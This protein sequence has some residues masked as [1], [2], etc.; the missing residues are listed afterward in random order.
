MG[1]LPRKSLTRERGEPDRGEL[2]RTRT[3]SCDPKQ[4]PVVSQALTYTDRKQKI[5]LRGCRALVRKRPKLIA[6]TR[7]DTVASTC[8][9]SEHIPY[10]NQFWTILGDNSCAINNGQIMSLEY[11]I[12]M[13]AKDLHRNLPTPRDIRTSLLHHQIV[14]CCRK[15]I[16]APTS[17][18]RDMRL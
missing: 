14:V 3:V 2:E 10:H 4:K 12:R 6:N 5:K 11:V 16:T 13:S 1:S 17:E 18:N 7:T 15:W 9:E 8:Q